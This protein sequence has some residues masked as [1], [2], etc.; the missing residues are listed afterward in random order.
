MA[1]S[2]FH[3]S[4]GRGPGA[5]SLHALTIKSAARCDYTENGGHGSRPVGSGLSDW[6]GR[7]LASAEPGVAAAFWLMPE[8]ALGLLHCTLPYVELVG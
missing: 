8:E 1:S 7:G 5:G 3:G 2:I 4:G 6:T